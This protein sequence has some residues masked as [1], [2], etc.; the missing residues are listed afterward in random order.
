MPGSQVFLFFALGAFFV[1]VVRQLGTML[2][3]LFRCFHGAP[4]QTRFDED[5]QALVAATRARVFGLWMSHGSVLDCFH[6]LS[7]VSWAMACW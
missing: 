2:I 6:F 3:A 4:F 1:T 7:K 5:R